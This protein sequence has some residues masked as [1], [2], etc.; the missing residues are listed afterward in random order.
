MENSRQILQV[1]TPSL[2]VREDILTFQCSCCL[3]AEFEGLIYGRTNEL[4]IC[5]PS[6]ACFVWCALCTLC[7]NRNGKEIR[8]IFLSPPPKK[9]KKDYVISTI[10]VEKKSPLSI[11]LSATVALIEAGI[12]SSNFVSFLWTLGPIFCGKISKSLFVI[13]TESLNPAPFSI[14]NLLAPEL[15][16]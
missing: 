6:N 12:S 7:R 5:S 1:Q 10:E 4:R 8:L 2:T 11:Y 3:F 16:F 15:F 13:L 9:K 14:F